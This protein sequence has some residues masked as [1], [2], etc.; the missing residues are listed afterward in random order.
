M[1]VPWEDLKREA[2]AALPYLERPDR[3]MLEEEAL[4]PSAWEDP[5][6]SEWAVLGQRALGAATKAYAPYSKY[7]V[8]AAL[9]SRSGEVYLGSNSEMATLQG[10]CAEANALASILSSAQPLDQVR[11]VA[12]ATL[13]D[14]P[15]RGPLPCA[16]CRYQLLGFGSK[17]TWIRSLGRSGS[18]ESVM[19]GT[20]LPH[21]HSMP[22]RWSVALMAFNGNVYTGVNT[23]LSSGQLMSAERNALA[24]LKQDIGGPRILEMKRRS[25]PILHA[26]HLYSPD[27][28]RGPW[29]QGLA[30]QDLAEWGLG[31]LMIRRSGG[32]GDDPVTRSLSDLYPAGFYFDFSE[33]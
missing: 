20:L 18:S 30:L 17:N 3:V 16:S 10:A 28:P 15:P 29:P 31:P 8:G 23:P 14:K 6:E 33:A 12:V 22:S 11:A 7:P 1:T 32:E 26:L 19:L 5:E 27:L 2:I 4:Q 9:L 25:L 24:A 21:A 13:A